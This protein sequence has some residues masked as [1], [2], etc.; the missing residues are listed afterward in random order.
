MVN[1]E[2]IKKLSD[3]F[4]VIAY[5]QFGVFGYDA[6]QQ[7]QWLMLSVSSVVFIELQVFAIMILGL[8]DKHE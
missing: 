3:T 1:K 5:A 4:S 8:G 2:Q 7:S 6:Y